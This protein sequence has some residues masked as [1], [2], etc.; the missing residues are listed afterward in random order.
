MSHQETSN[1]YYFESSPIWRAIVHMSLPMMLGMSMNII[2]NI[3]DAFFIGK[4]NQTAMMSAVTLALPFTTILMAV[5]NLFGTGGGTFISRL[6]GDKKLE[7]AK[8]VSSVTFYFS[9]LAG[10]MLMMICIP[11]LHPILQLL[12]ARK[13]ALLLT[14]E[15]I[16]VF[17][18]G[19]PLVIANFALEQVVRAEGASTAS[20]NGM[21]LSVIVNIVLDPFLIFF[22]HMNIAGAALGTIIGNLCAVVYYVV[23]LQKKSPALTVSVNAF[24]PSFHRT[25]EIFKIGVSA[26]LMDDLTAKT[27]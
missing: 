10:L 21:G 18:I 25:K 9:L 12:G 6:L 5:G 22:C 20:M 13:D 16:L 1:S 19:S 15:F 8:I 27:P 3:V 23:Y 4:L 24:K 17:I 7:E 11:L 26:L 14:Q 2:Y